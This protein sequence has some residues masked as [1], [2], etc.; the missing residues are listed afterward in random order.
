[1]LL[2]AWICFVICCFHRLLNDAFDKLFPGWVTGDCDP[3]EDIGDYW[4]SLDMHDLG[5]TYHEEMKG[6]NLF[7]IYGPDKFKMM[8]D[9][10]FGR[11]ETEYK[12]RMGI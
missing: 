8:D 5:Y 3:N 6:R 12:E 11:L 4:K 2:M 1:M 9:Y 7:N 10:S